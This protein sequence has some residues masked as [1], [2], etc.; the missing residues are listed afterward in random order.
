MSLRAVILILMRRIR[1]IYSVNGVAIAE[2][3][4]GM[5]YGID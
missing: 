1:Y 4:V 3:I 5:Q 2:R